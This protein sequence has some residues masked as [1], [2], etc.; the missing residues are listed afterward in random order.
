MSGHMVMLPVRLRCGGW[1]I[2][3]DLAR[4]WANS[5]ARGVVRV[6]FESD[7]K[8]CR[9]YNLVSTRTLC[10]QSCRAASRD[11]SSHLVSTSTKVTL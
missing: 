10:S 5:Q 1:R 7:Q 11:R 8:P 9:S 3:A 4:A 6:G 2:L